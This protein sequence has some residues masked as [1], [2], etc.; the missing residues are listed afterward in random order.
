[1]TKRDDG[2]AGIG[3]AD[4]AYDSRGRLVL[5]T[6]LNA[7]DGDL[8]QYRTTLRARVAAN[9]RKFGRFVEIASSLW[10][11]EAGEHYP[12]DAA[13]AF[14]ERDTLHLVYPTYTW[15]RASN[16]QRLDLL[17]RRSTDGGR[18]FTDEVHLSGDDLVHAS[19]TSQAPRV[20]AR[21]GAVVAAFGALRNSSPYLDPFPRVVEA[22]VNVVVSGDGGATWGPITE[23]SGRYGWA[24]G[25]SGGVLPDGTAVVTF[26][27]R[28]PG[29]FDRFVVR[30]R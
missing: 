13:I 15:D 4:V 19:A 6:R 23:L 14:D 11:N 20:F 24:A 3:E 16:V 25:F 10:P 9:G 18:T 2:Y 26:D 5:V 1:M 7:F 21:G 17:A 12:F 29:Y 28:S 30:V 27:D 22:G 8:G